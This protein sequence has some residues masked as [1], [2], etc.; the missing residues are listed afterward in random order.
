MSSLDTEQKPSRRLWILAGL[1]AFALHVGGGALATGLHAG[2]TKSS[3]SVER[4]HEASAAVR[5]VNRDGDVI[6]SATKESLGGKFHGA[7]AD[8]ADKIA[9]QLAQD[10]ARARSASSATQAGNPSR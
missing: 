7:S 9:K 3:R 2:G 4:K 5:L 1:A 10:I 6:W 8:V